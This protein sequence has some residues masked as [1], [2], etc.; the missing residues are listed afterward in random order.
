MIQGSALNMSDKLLAGMECAEGKL[1]ADQTAFTAEEVERI[2]ERIVA[3]F[4]VESASPALI[5]SLEAGE[6]TYE[7]CVASVQRHAK[8]HDV[9]RSAFYL[10]RYVI[11]PR[12]R[13][14]GDSSS[15]TRSPFMILMR[16]RRS[17]PAMVART[18]IPAS[19][20][21]ENIPALNFSMTFPS[22][23]MESS[24]GKFILDSVVRYGVRA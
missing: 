10:C 22:T 3:G 7:R 15:D 23:S 6:R 11:R 17:L 14:Y 18:F 8:S 13:S 21:M 16:L 9:H 5:K 20:S 12:V 2:R 1:L 24:L 19:N 4:S